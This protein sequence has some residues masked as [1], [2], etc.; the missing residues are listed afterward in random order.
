M[1]LTYVTTQI[2]NFN[3]TNGS[4]EAEFLVDTSDIDSIAPGNELGHKTYEKGH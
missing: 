3:K 1:G 4:Y 2:Y